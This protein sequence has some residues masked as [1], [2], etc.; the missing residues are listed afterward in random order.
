MPPRSVEMPPFGLACMSGTISHPGLLGSSGPMPFPNLLLTPL[1]QRHSEPLRERPVP[2][3][4]ACLALPGVAGRG[5][6][7]LPARPVLP[8]PLRSAL[9]SRVSGGRRALQELHEAV[10]GPASAALGASGQLRAGGCRV[11]GVWGPASVSDTMDPGP[12]AI[13][14]PSVSAFEVVRRLFVRQAALALGLEVVYGLD[15]FEPIP[16]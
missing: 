1:K 14:T 15:A 2:A 12:R 6:G 4:P 3:V 5:L 16:R 13:W 10:P 8:Q 7:R 11:A 9:A